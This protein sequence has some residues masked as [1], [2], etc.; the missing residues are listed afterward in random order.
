VLDNLVAGWP[1]DNLPALIDDV[2]RQLQPDL[3]SAHVLYDICAKR[4][5]P[6]QLVPLAA[7][8]AQRAEIEAPTLAGTEAAKVWLEA[9]QLYTQLGDDDAALRCV[10]NALQCDPGSYSVHYQLGFCLLKQGQFAE[11]ESHARWCLLRTP[12]DSDAANLLRAALKGRLDGQRRA[13]TE[14]ELPFTR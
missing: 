6:E 5:S 8:R 1:A 10:A 12:N 2:L 4:C 7:Y 3:E 9:Q 14:K 13:A 11:A